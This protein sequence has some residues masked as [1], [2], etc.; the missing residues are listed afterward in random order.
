MPRPSRMFLSLIQKENGALKVCANYSLEGAAAA[1]FAHHTTTKPDMS[2]AKVGAYKGAI[3][4]LIKSKN[5]QMY[6]DDMEHIILTVE[7]KP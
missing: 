4:N 3:E 5:K 7:L 1:I 2:L 6:L